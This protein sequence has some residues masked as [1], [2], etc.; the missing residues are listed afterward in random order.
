MHVIVL[1]A[2]DCKMEKSE[3]TNLYFLRT[4][5]KNEIALNQGK[6]TKFYWV[7]DGDKHCKEDK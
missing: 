7:L 2:R 6:L 1:G 4:R 3:K 5:E